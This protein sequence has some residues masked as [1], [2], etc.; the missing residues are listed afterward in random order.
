MWFNVNIKNIDLTRQDKYP[1]MVTDIRN[2]SPMS[3]I[4]ESVSL[5][6]VTTFSV[7]F[8]FCRESA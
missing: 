1:V 3:S 5:G 2:V 4:E 6:Y 8:C 7:V